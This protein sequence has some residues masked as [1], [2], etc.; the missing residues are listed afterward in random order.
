MGKVVT[1]ILAAGNGNPN[2]WQSKEFP[3]KVMVPIGGVPLVRRTVLQLEKLGIKAVVATAYSAVKAVVPRATKPKRCDSYTDTWMSTSHLWKKAD[4][5][6]F[7]NG[8]TVWHPTALNY[9]V[10]SKKSPA[11]YGDTMGQVYGW[12]FNLGHLCK[13]LV[14]TLGVLHA[15]SQVHFFRNLCGCSQLKE[16]KFFYPVVPADTYTR[17]IDLFKDYKAWLSNHSDVT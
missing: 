11:I 9:V 10:R 6:L 13:V 8:D 7:L 15:Y 17:D 14:A 2:K 12:A 1:I 3:L 4:R 5:V 16:C